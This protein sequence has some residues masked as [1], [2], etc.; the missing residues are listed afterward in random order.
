MHKIKDLTPLQQL[1]RDL[2]N[3]CVEKYSVGEAESKIR[4]KLDEVTGGD[5]SW[6]SIQGNKKFFAI[7]EELVSVEVARIVE[8][9]FP[10]VEFKN[11][12]L[13]EKADFRVENT[14]LFDMS[15]VSTGV[16]KARRQRLLDNKVETKPFN[17]NCSI[18][19]EFFKFR[20]GKINWA[21]MIDNVAKSFKTQLAI[22]ISHAIQEA[23]KGLHTNMKVSANY[24]DKDLAKLIAKVG[25]KVQIFGTSEA[26][27][28]IVG[29]A[30][31]AD[32]NDKRD[33]GYVKIFNG[34]PCIE[35]P[36]YYDKETNKWAVR[37]DLLY[38]VPA[39]GDAM[40][41]C[42]FEGEAL[43]IENTDPKVRQDRQVD[44]Y[45]EQIVHLAALSTMH[46]GAYEIV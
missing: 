43:V 17:L 39:D 41:R 4:E 5:Y 32:A 37:N 3:G 16:N 21:R 10:W 28:N 35:L 15:A 44:F 30:A 6:R 11:F 33:Y 38:I 31:I 29:A 20:T 45:F 2:Y 14:D 23:Y 1:S 40:V 42:G 12:A 19:E 36:Q 26:L 24:T 13:G 27:A 18:Y 25:G 7:L 22:Q 8:T 46:F 9:D 34:A